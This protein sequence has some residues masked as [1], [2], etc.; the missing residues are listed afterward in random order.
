MLNRS[1]R[2]VREEVVALLRETGLTTVFANGA[3]PGAARPPGWPEDLR[4]VLALHEGAVVGMAT[5]WAIAR[6]APAL[7][8]LHATAGLG[9]AA[10]ALAIARVSR[11]PLVV[12]VSRPGRRHLVDEP[13]LP[14]EHAVWVT[15]PARA[16]DVPSAVARARHEAVTGRGPALVVVPEDDWD[17]PGSGLGVSAPKQIVR[18]RA[19]GDGE[20]APLAR[21]LDGARSPALVAGAGADSPAAWAGLVALAERLGSPVFQDSSGARAGFPQDH[22]LFAGVL[23]ADRPALRRALGGHDVVLVVGAAAFCQHPYREGPFAQPGTTVAVVSDDAAELHRSWAEVALRA[24]PGVAARRLAE[25][26]RPRDSRPVDRVVPEPGE[27]FRAAHVLAALAERLPPETVVVEETP[28][29]RPDLHRLLPARR[30]L[31]LVSAATGGPGFALP[32]AA[33]L[34]MALPARPVVAVVG[35]R[36]A[37]Y[38]VQ[39]LWSA[40]HYGVGA[41]FVVLSNFPD[42]S[43]AGLARAQGCDAIEITDRATLVDTLDGVIPTL[44]E[45]SEPLLLDIAVTP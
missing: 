45:R 13:F 44:T 37:M 30:P 22:R 40:A 41:L 17:A 5:G 14:G 38:G 4:F 1:P 24:D 27:G 11:A 36:S 9:N 12:L 19:V 28:S 2:G 7:V 35:D 34:R 3:A 6:D 23:P 33:G 18:T 21:L 29:S 10:G 16:Q 42:I 43:L 32:A 20:L 15:T 31:G 26:V 39:A 8:L 25:L